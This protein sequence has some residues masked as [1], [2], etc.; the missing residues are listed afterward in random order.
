MMHDLG[1]KEEPCPRWFADFCA[2]TVPACLS[3][4]FLLTDN[5]RTNVPARG[6]PMVTKYS[7]TLQA[8]EMKYS[9]VNQ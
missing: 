5:E 8:W 3:L 6:C 9:W 7:L 2:H 4:Y 1:A